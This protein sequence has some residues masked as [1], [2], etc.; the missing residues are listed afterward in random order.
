ME[1]TPIRSVWVLFC[2]TLVIA[3]QD[4]SASG[5]DYRNDELVRHSSTNWPK[6]LDML[7]NATNRVH[8]FWM[9]QEDM[10]FFTGDASELTAFLL[11]C[12]QAD[13]V[14]S[15]RVVIHEG[16]GEAKSPWGKGVG[17][18]CDWK[19]YACPKGFHNV[20]T[21]AMTTGVPDKKSLEELRKAGSEAGY[22]LEVHFW[23]GGHI[24]PGN[25]QVPKNFEIKKE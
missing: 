8:G 20:M 22:I 18:A 14:V 4:A 25:I 11:E 6:Q 2:F 1:T 13:G 7:V 5:S 12:S 24:A 10:F 19:L 17:R 23:T 16:I 3:T 21:L 9:N 15:R